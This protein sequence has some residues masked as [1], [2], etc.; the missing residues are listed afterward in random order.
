MSMSLCTRCLNRLQLQVHPSQ[1]LVGA[2]V[3]SIQSTAFHTSS[4]RHVVGGRGKIVYRNLTPKVSSSKTRK[5]EKQR[6][7]PP[8]ERQQQRKRIVLSNTNAP[9]VKGLQPLTLQNCADQNVVGRILSF[10]DATIDRLRASKAF[11]KTQSWRLFRR[12]A[13][14]MR[15]ESVEI[16]NL[17]AR[18]G[19]KT[20]TDR[21]VVAGERISGKSVLLTQA[22]AMA[23]M[24]EWV[25]I[26][27]PE[28]MLAERDC[29]G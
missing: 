16:G 23:L 3:S 24:K 27:V 6:P 25:L 12:P 22:S 11:K 1:L 13:T 28:G 2:A 21:I 29:D 5:R 15:K 7:P 26:T 17:I 20:T 8:G 9:E 10:D 19:L 18:E 4:S 14:L